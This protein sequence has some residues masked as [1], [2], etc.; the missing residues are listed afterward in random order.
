LKQRRS[1]DVQAAA[2]WPG[3]PHTKHPRRL[4]GKAMFLQVVEGDKG[5]RGGSG[6]P[7]GD[8]EVQRSDERAQRVGEG[9]EDAAR[10]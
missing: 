10:V 6:E 5:G 1:V 8:G 4:R 2:R 7:G 9:C 3:R